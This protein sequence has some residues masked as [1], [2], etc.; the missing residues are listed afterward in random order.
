MINLVNA[1]EREALSEYSDIDQQLEK[2]YWRSG[3]TELA[4]G[5]RTLTLQQ[6]EKKY[7]P[8]FKATG[9]KQRDKNLRKLYLKNFPQSETVIQSL[10]ELDTLSNVH[11]PLAHLRAAGHYLHK[12]PRDIEATGGT[13]WQKF[14][15]PRFQKIIFFPEL[16]TQQEMTDWG[17]AAF[18]N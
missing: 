18:E 8:V 1:A 7:M 13:N 15:P 2:L 11:W 9:M 4:S 12:N 10:R 14:L 3:A 16:W 17:K 5:K 6:F